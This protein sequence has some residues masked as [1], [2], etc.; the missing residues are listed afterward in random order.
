MP[1]LIFT[2]EEFLQIRELV[3]QLENADATRQKSIRNKIRKIG[4]HWSKVGNRMTY[5]EENLMKLYN[6]GIIGIAGDIPHINDKP[7]VNS[8][9]YPINHMPATRKNSDESYVIDLCDESLGITAKRQHRFD[10]LR[11]DSGTCLPVDAYYPSL[12]LVVEYHERQHSESVPLFDKRMTV[13]GVTRGEQ[14]RLYDLRREQVLPEHGI[15]LVVISYKDF[16][17]SKTLKRDK[18]NDIR[19]VKNILAEFTK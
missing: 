8:N 19:I 15:K 18:A 13:S 3:K 1:D 4:L 2:K 9:E 14:R 17:S 6:S 16:G 12:N 10:F 5:N 7:S 11:G